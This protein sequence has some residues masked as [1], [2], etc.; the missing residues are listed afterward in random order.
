MATI[1]NGIFSYGNDI[2]VEQDG[3]GRMWLYID[4]VELKG[5]REFE[6]HNAVDEVPTITITFIP[7]TVNSKIN[8][9]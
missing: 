8:F 1:T 3:H 5:I 2:V 6:I 9:K 7:K 4:G